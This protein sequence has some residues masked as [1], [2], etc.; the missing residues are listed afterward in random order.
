[1]TRFLFLAVGMVMALAAHP[2]PGAITFRTVA[3]TGQQAAGL[4]TGTSYLS[5]DRLQLNDSG[6]TAF[7]ARLI[8]N[9]VTSANDSA[10]YAEVRDTGLQV[11]ARTGDQAPGLPI[12]VS[13]SS[14]YDS[15]PAGSSGMRFNDAGKVAYPVK[16]SGAGVDNTNDTAIY[17]NRDGNTPAVLARAGEQAPGL[18]NG[19]TFSG[20][21]YA[22]LRFNAA[23]H[24][25]FLASLS[26]AGGVGSYSD[27]IFSEGGGDGLAA[28]AYRGGLA[29][30]LPTGV[31]VGAINQLTRFEL[32]DSGEI[33]FDTPL[34]GEGVTSSNDSAILRGREAESLLVIAR[35]GEQ[36]PGLPQGVVYRI[37]DLPQI[38]RKG[39]AAF[40]AYLADGAATDISNKGLFSEHPG[41]GLTPVVY[42]GDQAAGLPAGVY[43]AG[44]GTPT[45]NSSGQTVFRSTLGGE[46]VTF[47]NDLAVFLSGSGGDVDLLVRAGDQAPEFPP[48]VK[49]N[50]ATTTLR[51]NDAGQVALRTHITP[52]G[53]SP[54]SRSA[55]YATDTMNAM[56]LVATEG[57]LLDVNDDPL[58]EDFRT[59]SSIRSFYDINNAGEVAFEV[60][61][62]DNS[63]GL[64]VARLQIPEPA[65]A[66]LAISAVLAATAPGVR[67]PRLPA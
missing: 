25:A 36:A 54:F 19:V 10:I 16:L 35:E 57:Q 6:Q 12:G 3:L 61:F 66:L 8:G 42:S 22:R 52:L 5:F 26:E 29:T 51:I 67:R 49:L 40:S 13:Y 31:G 37:F 9:G 11:V 45:M 46:G 59:I 2:A 18:P 17:S 53:D 47:T 7:V 39:N 20:F 33:V 62:T 48:G 56:H 1:M 4:P 41:V 38:N 14:F 28:F 44:N 15:V 43:Y 55:I 50:L 63:S 60:R 30:G 64:F 32:S 27:A 34:I 21:N 58:I 23:G 65:A 24:T